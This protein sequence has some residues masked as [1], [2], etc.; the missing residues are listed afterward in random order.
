MNDVIL[1]HVSVRKFA[2]KPVETQ[3][4]QKIYEAAV[5][6]SNTGN[7]QWYSIIETTDSELKQRLRKECHFNQAMV[8]DAPVVLTFC[9]DINRFNKWCELN[10]A[11]PGYDNFLSFYT[12]SVDTIIAAQNA[13]IAAESFGLGICYLGT[14]NYTAERIIKILQLPQ[15]VVPVTTIVLGYPDE[16]PLQTDRLPI[17]AIVHKQ[18]YHDYSNE[19][20]KTIYNQKD[21]SEFYKD[22]V[23]TN[24]VETLAHVFTEKRY[25]VQN[26]IAF[27]KSL[28][29]VLIKQGFMNQ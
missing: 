17:D 18:V 23:K 28:I 11:Q 2:N 22:I 15:G 19:S 6:A 13:C 5:R 12:A 4:L 8:E 29:D 7:M 21:T 26:N 27:S 10:N 9:A 3:L 14:T 24:N 16:K 1:N 25:A 20:I